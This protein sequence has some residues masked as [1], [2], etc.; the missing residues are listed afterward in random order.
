MTHT[1]KTRWIPKQSIPVEHPQGLGVAYVYRAGA[2]YAAVAYG[3]KRTK[4]DFH[5][6]YP[7]IEKAHDAIEQWFLSLER[8]LAARAERRKTSY[9]PHTFKVGDIVTNSWGYD[10]TNVDWYR[11]VRTTASF[12]WLQPIC[13]DTTETGFM[14]GQ[15][16]PSVDTSDADP[17]KWGFRDKGAVTKHKASGSNCTM[18][19]GCG[20]KW[21]GQTKYASWY[22]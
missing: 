22:A 5:Y 17:S 10:Q 9:A 21:D 11:V 16:S 4:S 14:S 7:S 20:S 3:M 1:F 8:H 2:R 19:Y 18:K 6:G 13:A 15:S 12:V